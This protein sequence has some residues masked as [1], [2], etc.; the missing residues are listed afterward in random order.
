MFSSA[1]I[2]CRS[3]HPST[4]FFRQNQACGLYRWVCNDRCS[5]KQCFLNE[6][7]GSYECCHEACAGGCTGKGAN[8]CVSCKAFSLDGECVASCP[9]RMVNDK[10]MGKLVPNPNGRFVYDRYCVKECPKELLIERETCVRHCSDGSHHDMTKNTR[11]CEECKGPCPKVCQLTKPLTGSL[12]RNLTNCEEIDGF[13]EIQDSRMQGKDGFNSSDLNVLKS[14]RMVSEYVQ[15]AAQTIS[16]GSLSFLEN[17]E[18]IEGR[19]LVS[20]KYSLVI[21]KNDNLR[22][23]GLR[24]LKTIKAGNV[25]IYENHMLC[26][27]NTIN[28]TSILQ[29]H[30]EAR[31]LTNMNE[32]KCAVRKLVCDPNCNPASGCWGL[33]PK[34]C[35][36]CRN[37]DLNGICVEKCP[38]TGYYEDDLTMICR[39]CY[40]QCLTCKGPGAHEC[41]SCRNM[42]LMDNSSRTCIDS[43]P[44]THYEEDKE[45]K[46]CHKSCY[47]LGCTGPRDSIGP[48]GC[49]QCKYAVITKNQTIDHCL[50]APSSQI[51]VCLA[52]NLQGHFTSALAMEGV[53]ELHCDPCDEE[54]VTCT[55]S[56]RSVLYNGCIC[57]GRSSC[58]ELCDRSFGCTGPSEFECK[59][60]SIAVVTGI[61]NEPNMCV[62]EC[63]EHLPF[64]DDQKICQEYDVKKKMK[65]VVG[66]V[67]M[68]VFL[69]LVA[70]IAVVYCRCITIERKLKKVE[71][72]NYID[73]P[74]VA[75]IDPTARSNMSRVNLITR[76]EL[77]TKGIQ[78]GAGAFGVV[79]AGYWF[80]KGKGKIKVPVA[81][82]LVKGA[83]KCTGKEESEMLDEAMK[84]S[85]MRHEHLLRL[86][87]VCLHEDGIQLI[88]LLRPLGNLLNFLKKHKTHLCGKDLLLY[89]YQIS[90][91]MKYLYEHRLV[92]RDLAARNVLVKRPN[93][94]EVTDFGL[95][96]MLDYGQDKVKVE[97]GK[98]SKFLT[99][100]SEVA[101]KWLALESLKEQCYNHRTDVWAFGVTCWEI[102]TFGQSPYQGMD[103]CA[104][105]NFLREGNRL[106]QPNNC[107]SELYQVLL[108][109]WMANP[110]S[111][112][113]F[114]MLN[115]RFLT[116]CRVPHLYVGDPSTPQTYVETTSQKDLLRE[117]LDDNDTDFTDPLNYFESENCASENPDLILESE[118]F[119]MPRTAC[120]LQSTGSHRYQTDPMIKTPSRPSELGTDSMNY[121]IPNAKISTEQH[122]TLYTPV[123]VNE[124]GTTELVSISDYY[125]EANHKADYYNEMKSTRRPLETMREIREVVEVEKVSSL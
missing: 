7:L 123:V 114:L 89:C 33:G 8:E 101:I 99:N 72:D 94:V 100:Y 20:Q 103:I 64:L 108:Q 122:A 104:I 105:K 42:A 96:K 28:W 115:E 31:I 38:N 73:I 80:P 125:N 50:F 37:W 5:S 53:E 85:M 97:E 61:G 29:K 54:C 120:R 2:V 83:D 111:R 68:S 21:T 81:I 36:K 69:I 113:T 12:L 47:D 65:V 70:V 63:P 119:P 109:C 41:I 93:H 1:R 45:C 67:V 4:P 43:C 24:K 82:K 77:H 11:Q 57:R 18:F 121:L 91:A 107:S 44:S 26:L 19:S 86:V 49:N 10:K 78:L 15:M 88:T 17:L 117:L 112:P 22:T 62:R 56:G 87:G 58:H 35:A 9:H 60:C 102:L 51:E 110:E 118:V 13:I 34:M 55:S 74:E 46:P 40:S 76:G 59:Q 92:H 32:S 3:R 116:F 95:A 27:A 23:L 71:I 106:S 48:G 39:P 14:V 30:G 124:N 75:P 66:T 84:M 25:I 98:V 6:T 79:Y 90:A 52:N 16:P